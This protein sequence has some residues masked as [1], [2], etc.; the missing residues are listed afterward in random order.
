MSRRDRTRI[1]AVGDVL[2]QRLFPDLVDKLL[3]DPE[4]DVRFQKRKPY[5]FER[6]LDV[7]LGN[8]P[9]PGQIPENAL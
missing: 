6:V 3:D 2:A 4:V 5:F 9:L 7:T 8:F 1:E